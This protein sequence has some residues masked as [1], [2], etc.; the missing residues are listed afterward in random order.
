MGDSEKPAFPR[1]NARN[2]SP[3]LDGSKIRL[4]NRILDHV[5]MSDAETTSQRRHQ[6]S[7]RPRM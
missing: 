4:L 2:G 6:T 1:L 3:A 7:L 5:E